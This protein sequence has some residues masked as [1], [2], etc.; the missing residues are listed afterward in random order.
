MT[1]GSRAAI[2][3][4]R[5][6]QRGAALV[7]FVIV[8]PVLLMLLFS[9]W[10]AGRIF[11]A[12]MISTN[13]A[14]EGARYAIE[15]TASSDPVQETLCQYVEKQVMAYVDSGYGDR[16]NAPGGDVTISGS[17]I[18]INGTA[19]TA[20]QCPAVN[21]PVAVGVTAHVEVFAPTP[22]TGFIAPGKTFAIGAWTTMYQ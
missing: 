9:I 12:W 15:W 6:R 19:V 11:D 17:D 3:R 18:T 4:A 2:D 10:E 5:P 21:G 14:R 16:V 7:E 22:F 13:A 1:T 20:A 8:A